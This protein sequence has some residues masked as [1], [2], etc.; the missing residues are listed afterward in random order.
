MLHCVLMTAVKCFPHKFMSA[1]A[2]TSDTNG[3]LMASISAHVS[4]VPVMVTRRNVMPLLAT[5]RLVM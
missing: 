3:H 1:R 4:C 5:A 2:V